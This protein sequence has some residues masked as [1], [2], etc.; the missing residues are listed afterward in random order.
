MLPDNGDVLVHAYMRSIG[1]H[2]V[3]R[4]AKSIWTTQFIRSNRD[5][6]SHLVYTWLHHDRRHSSTELC[7][8]CFSVLQ[9]TSDELGWVISLC[10][11]I[12]ASRELRWVRADEIKIAVLQNYRNAG[13]RFRPLREWFCSGNAHN[14]G[15]CIQYARAIV[16]QND[17][18]PR[19]WASLQLDHRTINVSH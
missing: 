9:S 16:Q 19:Q 6:Q 10:G 5:E 11:R 13:V 12:Y 2:N 1:R 4:A 15:K 14:S 17:T 3:W 7:L 18:V 8:V